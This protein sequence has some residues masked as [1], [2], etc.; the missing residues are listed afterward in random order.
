N[1]GPWAF[2]I[3]NTSAPNRGLEI[4]Q[5]DSGTSQIWSNYNAGAGALIA[6]HS[7]GNVGVGMTNPSAKLVVASPQ[8]NA[9]NT[10]IAEFSKDGG[11]NSYGSA[12]VRLSRSIGGNS[13]DM[14]L[15]SG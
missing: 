8:T 15:N 3:R 12:I 11:T 2:R 10:V 7:S 6:L 14:E 1:G 13:T 9:T 5:D 4:F